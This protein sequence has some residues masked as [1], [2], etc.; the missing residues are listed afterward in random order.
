[1]L[2]YSVAKLA[3]AVM[4]YIGLRLP[5]FVAPQCED[6][7]AVHGFIQHVTSRS[8]TEII[9]IGPECSV[10]SQPVANLAPFWNLVQVRHK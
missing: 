9:I 8:E 6:T 10:S 5:W 7:P 1:M 2:F 3:R 4:T